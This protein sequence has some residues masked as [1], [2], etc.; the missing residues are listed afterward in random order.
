LKTLTEATVEAA[1][2]PSLKELG[3]SRTSAQVVISIYDIP[4][5]VADKATVPIYYESHVAKLG[6]N[7]SELPKIDE[8]FEAITSTTKVAA[9]S[10]R[11]RAC[12]PRR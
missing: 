10:A 9:S 11:V 7:E 2:I 6:L 12:S 5:A 3:Y 1:A 4:P 8:E